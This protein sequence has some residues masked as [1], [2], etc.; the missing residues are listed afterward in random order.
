MTQREVILRAITNEWSWIQAA[1]VLGVT[2]DRMRDIR[3]GIETYGLTLDIDRR[4]GR[5]RYERVSTDAIRKM[6]QLRREHRG[7]SFSQFYNLV[8]AQHDLNLSLQC[9]RL[10]L[11]NC[12]HNIA[13]QMCEAESVSEPVSTSLARIVARDPDIHDNAVRTGV[14][15]QGEPLRQ[16]EYKPLDPTP[17]NVT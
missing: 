2:P 10:L 17:R 7:F 13:R 9:L 12:D 4:G 1:E 15:T 6:Y 16:R 5:V 8:K 11:Q 3:I 14:R